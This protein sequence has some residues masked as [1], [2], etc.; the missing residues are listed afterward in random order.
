M[1]IQV[2]DICIFD[3][4]ND[5]NLAGS[6]MNFVK[7]TKKE[8]GFFRYIY[9]GVFCDEKG[10]VVGNVEMQFPARLLTPCDNTKQVIVRYPKD[11]P[12]VNRTEVEALKAMYEKYL[13]QG[14]R[15]DTA[16]EKL[17][18]KLELFS[19]IIHEY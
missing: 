9:H 16:V 15:K 14:N 6:A 19:T 12:I 8:L 10:I 1:S 2:G 3:K 18:L 4:D 17:I 13:S 7:I 11:V 5:M